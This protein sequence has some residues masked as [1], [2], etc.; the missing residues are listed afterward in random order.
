MRLDPSVQE[1]QKELEE[2]TVLLKQSSDAAQNKPRK[3]VPIIEV[4][5]PGSF[6]GLDV[7]VLVWRIE[8]KINQREF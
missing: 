5:T 1:A 8:L 6:V 3:T 4:Q 2:V 7:G